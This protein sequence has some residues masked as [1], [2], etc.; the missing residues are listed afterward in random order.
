MRPQPE[1]GLNARGRAP[2]RGNILKT[3]AV[4]AAAL[5][6]T[7]APAPALAQSLGDAMASAYKSSG[8]LEQNRAN[9]RATDEGVAAALANLRP[10]LNYE[11]NSSRSAFNGD[12]ADDWT[13]TLT[14]VAQMNVYTFGRDQLSVDSAKE[15]VLATRQS[16]VNVEQQVLANAVSAYQNVREAQALVNLRQNAVRLNTQNLRAARDRFEV[17]EITRTQVSQFEAQ[18]ASVKAQL[19]AAQGTLSSAREAYRVAVGSYPNKLS[20]PPRVAFN[21]RSADE[22]VAR[23]KRNHPLIKSLQ[24]Q[25]AAADLAV[26]IAEKQLLPT[27]NARVTQSFT[28]T[29]TANDSSSVNLGISGPIYNGGALSSSVRRA[30]ALRDATRAQLLQTTREVEQDVR[31]NWALLSVNAASEQA[32][33]SL[34]EAQRVALNGVREEADLGAATTLDVLDAEQD[35]LD[36]QVSAIQSRISRE[37]Q[38]YSVLQSTGQLTVASLKLNV[39]VY[40]PS[41]YYNAVKSGSTRY[42][43]P[44]GDKLDRVLESIGRN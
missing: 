9:L 24:H 44:Q 28:K 13:H 37:S 35:L 19:A 2:L 30:I 22:A 10:S 34:V 12:W 4:G 26:M 5:M 15:T 40:D 16:L 14:F 8:L 3:L 1:A 21:A 25:V 7:L 18:L 29:T 27:V 43:S 41:A 42:V 20:S 31:S 32:A 38:A 39:P 33:L 17:G 36:A 6:V 23:A 11:F